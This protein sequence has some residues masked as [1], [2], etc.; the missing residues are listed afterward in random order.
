M[1]LILKVIPELKQKLNKTEVNIEVAQKKSSQLSIELDQAEDQHDVD[2]QTI[3]KL[4]QE[5]NALM[6]KL[7]RAERDIR[8]AE[9]ARDRAEDLVSSLQDS[10]KTLRTKNDK[11]DSDLL[12]AQE[13]IRELE[14]ELNK[15]LAE[16]E[17]KTYNVNVV[18]IEPILESPPPGFSFGDNLLRD[19]NEIL[20]KKVEELSDKVKRLEGKNT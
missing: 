8:A 6:E 16:P 9:D 14:N 18:E 2:E 12:S 13:R 1:H 15:R 3:E 19:E 10:E 4:R 17:L 11:L 5:K 7:S 20:K